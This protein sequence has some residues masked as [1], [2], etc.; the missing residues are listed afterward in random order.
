MENAIEQKRTKGTKKGGGS[1]QGAKEPRKA[2]AQKPA[3][4]SMEYRSIQL[5]DLGQDFTRF[6]VRTSNGEILAAHPFQ[7]SIWS[8]FRITNH[9]ALRVG[10]RP[11]LK[12]PGHAL[13]LRYRVVK[14]GEVQTG[15]FFE[16]ADVLAMKGGAK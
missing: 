15:E 6:D 16:L 4:V 13:T 14:I 2:D 11:I 9:K 3:P 8:E 12:K 1:R 5:E 10:D 7:G